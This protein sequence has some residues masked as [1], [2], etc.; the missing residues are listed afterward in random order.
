MDLLVAR[1]SRLVYND[2]EDDYFSASIRGKNSRQF[3]PPTPPPLEGQRERTRPG[4]MKTDPK[5]KGLSSVSTPA[6]LTNILH[7]S[8]SRHKSRTPSNIIPASSLSVKSVQ[9]HS[10]FLLLLFS[11][12]GLFLLI[13]FCVNT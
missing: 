3:W 13:F 5:R 10:P 1:H 6:S 4:K 9:K 7:R 2:A 11:I 12:A 8:L